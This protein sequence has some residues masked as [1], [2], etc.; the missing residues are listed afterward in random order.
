MLR[1]LAGV[2]LAIQSVRHKSALQAVTSKLRLGGSGGV[3]FLES[4]DINLLC[5][6]VN[7]LAVTLDPLECSNCCTSCTVT[8]TSARRSDAHS[9]HMQPANGPIVIEA[10]PGIYVGWDTS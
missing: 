2:E 1:V 9:M 4:G 5:N 3:I 7:S 8:P 6:D 10:H